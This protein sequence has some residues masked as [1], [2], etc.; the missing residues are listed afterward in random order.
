MK[1]KFMI[2]LLGLMLVSCGEVS[3]LS[4]STSNSLIESI[5][6]SDSL[7]I[8]T[9][10]SNSLIQSTSTSNSLAGNT[11]LTKQEWNDAFSY[12]YNSNFTYNTISVG[13]GVTSTMIVTC[14]ND[15][16][17]LTAKNV[18]D[19]FTMYY[20][21][22]GDNYYVYNNDNGWKKRESQKEE[23]ENVRHALTFAINQY[24]SFMYDSESN[25]YSANNI[26]GFITSDNKFTITFDST[27]KKLATI[28]QEYTYSNVDFVAD[29]TIGYVT[30]AISLPVVE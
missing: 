1:N 12:F 16:C 21:K 27:N 24:D 9:P 18:N 30:E 23:Y 5:S 14:H 4:T 29:I 8:S 3:S 7:T 28:H 10:T 26:E 15:V 13:A 25:S 22:N 2:V 19:D 6:T 20:E 11:A 17:S